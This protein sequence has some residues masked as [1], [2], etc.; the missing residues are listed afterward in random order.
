MSKV[1]IETWIFSGGYDGSQMSIDADHRKLSKGSVN[2]I[3]TGNGKPQAFKK[4][5]V[6]SDVPVARRGSLFLTNAGEG[7]AGLG[8]F[9]DTDA[10][11]SVFR[12]LSALFFVGGGGNPNPNPTPNPALLRYNGVSL[13]ASASSRLQ[14]KLLTGGV[15]STETYQ[16]GLARPAAPTLA[17]LATPSAGF[18]GKLKNG[19]YSAKIIK[20]RSSTGV[21]SLASL[22]SNTIV[23]VE[24]SGVGKTARIT[25]DDIGFNGANRWGIYVSPR[26]FGSTGPHYFL[27][28]VNV[29]DLGTVDGVPRSLEIEWSDGDLVGGDLAPIDSF[30]P[31]AAM[32]GGALGDSAFLDGCYGDTVSNPNTGGVSSGAPGSTIVQSLPLRPEEYPPDWTIYPPEAPTALLRGGDGFYYRFGASSMGVISYVGGTGNSPPLAFQLMWA[33]MGITYAHNATVGTGGKLYAKCGKNL[34]RIGA[35]GEPE[36]SWAAPVADQMA[37]L[38]D[39]FTVLGWD[40][41]SHSLVVMNQR[42]MWVYNEQ[43]DAWGAPIDETPT[44]SGNITAAVT[45]ANSL[46]IAAKDT[47]ASDIKLYTYNTGS[48]SLMRSVTDWHFS[49]AEADTLRQLDCVMRADNTTNAVTVDVYANEND[50]APVVTQTLTVR[51]TGTVK[52]PPVRICLPGLESVSYT[53]LTL[54]TKRIV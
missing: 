5:S 52:L 41:D 30:A 12:I 19:T 42:K 49:S 31:P 50:T 17:T 23:A 40:G 34:V 54:P 36:T 46:I 43:L 44:F 29:T 9:G 39:Q 2:Q 25:F 15:Y 3:I 27:K 53:H 6:F 26:N 10:K 1:P 7:Y 32:F 33:N 16:A 28:E 13:G 37:V 24:S 51:K 11:G 21:R 22:V 47:V 8:S 14:L 18:T 35:D 4:N 38:D 48:G 20:I 45:Q